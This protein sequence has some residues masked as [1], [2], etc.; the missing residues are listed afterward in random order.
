[1]HWFVAAL[2]GPLLS[3]TGN[4]VG[5]VLL[6]LGLGFIT[7]QGINAGLQWILQAITANLASVNGI[8]AGIMGVLRVD[9]V[10]T[11]LLSAVAVRLTMTG[12][13]EGGKRL[14]NK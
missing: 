8:I 1:M 7:Y 12:I 9:Q 3:L 11:I 4:F 2:L 6:S 10:I 13:V 5:R 14:V